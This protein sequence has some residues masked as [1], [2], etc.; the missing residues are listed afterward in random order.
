LH[1]CKSNWNE[2]NLPPPETDYFGRQINQWIRVALISPSGLFTPSFLIF[3]LFDRLFHPPNH[4]AC[5]LVTIWPVALPLGADLLN[6]LIRFKNRFSE[7]SIYS[8][9]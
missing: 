9:D 5:P 3:F 6:L 7:Y 2:R 1:C 8:A 4:C